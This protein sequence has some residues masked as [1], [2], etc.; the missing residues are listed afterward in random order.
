MKKI[1]SNPADHLFPMQFRLKP[2]RIHFVQ[3]LGYA[4]GIC[5]TQCVEFEVQKY[6]GHP[7]FPISMDAVQR[8]SAEATSGNPV[9]SHTSSNICVV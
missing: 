8:S 4:V 2:F 7:E 5:H 9:D 3:A 6:Q 1:I